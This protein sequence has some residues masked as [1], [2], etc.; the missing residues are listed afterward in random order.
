MHEFGKL[1]APMHEFAGTPCHPTPGHYAGCMELKVNVVATNTTTPCGGSPTTILSACHP[2]PGHYAGGMKL[3]V[4][5]VATNP[6]NPSGGSPPTTVSARHLTPGHCAGSMK[7]KM[8]VVA[9]NTN[10]PCGG[11]PPTSPSNPSPYTPFDSGTPPTTTSLMPSE[12]VS[13]SSG[14]PF[15]VCSSYCL[16][17]L[18]LGNRQCDV[19]FLVC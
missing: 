5:V 15:H 9:T 18:G 12:A 13:V 6:T 7:L 8:N 3:K 4:N 16:W 19:F 17:F 14:K 10:T 11:S 2:T 1:A